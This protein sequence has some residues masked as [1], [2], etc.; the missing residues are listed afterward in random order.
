MRIFK[1]LLDL[2]NYIPNCI[3]C[4][5]NMRLSI[6]GYASIVSP[7]K[8]RWGS[9][10]ERLYLKMELKDGVFRG[11]HKNHNVSIEAT[12]NKLIEGEDITNRLMLNTINVKTCCPTCV[13]KSIC[14][15]QAGNTKKTNCFPPV[16]LRTEELSYTMHG[17]KHCMITKHYMLN[18]KEEAKCF[19]AINKVS[20]QPVPLDFT[21]F[22]SLEQINKK[23]KTIAVFS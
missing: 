1:T 22:T 17:G 11:K 7:S 19:I 16:A 9:G 5:K 8:P 10:N 3:I 13:F 14:V 2:L 20:L 18:D 4:G 12:T 6:E 21:K 23:I 15:Y